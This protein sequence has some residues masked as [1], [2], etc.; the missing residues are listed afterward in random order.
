MSTREL[1]VAVVADWGYAKPDLSALMMDDVHVLMTA[2]DNV[3]NLHASGRE[4]VKA[5]AALIDSQPA[6]FRRIP[7]MP[8]LGNHDR[9]I[10][11]RGPKPPPEAVYDV[12]ATAYRE[13]FALPGDEWR[14]TFSFPDFSARF[15]ALDLN[16]IR[17]FGTT[18]QT[19][20]AYLQGRV[21][22]RQTYPA[23]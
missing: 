5:F 9:E 20:H 1:R 10:R 3:P 22:D 13:F 23:R 17:D 12:E 7:F 4:G 14:W 18:W 16:H 2:G 11:P 15:I 8:V 6:L 19:C 21:L